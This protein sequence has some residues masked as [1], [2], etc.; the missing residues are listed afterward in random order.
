MILS[1]RVLVLNR[2]WQPVNIVGMRRAVALIFVGQ[3]SFIRR[4]DSRVDVIGLDAWIEWSRKNPPAHGLVAT[5]VT[6]HAPEVL[7][8]SGYDR[9]PRHEVRFSRKHVL[10]RD[11]CRCQYCGGTF[12]EAELNLDHVVP[13]ER[14]G[15]TSWENIVTACLRCNARKADRLPHQVGMRLAHAP[16]RP[17]WRAFAARGFSGDERA[18]WRHFWPM[19]EKKPPGLP[20][21][22]NGTGSQ[23]RTDVICVEGRGPTAERYPHTV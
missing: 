3:A 18:A 23:D 10:Q 21:V 5:K 14:G 4:D 13:R 2:H 6:L 11:G 19:D 16:S 20:A 12:S 8:L 7:L 15:R 17:S 22:S 1:R 9:S